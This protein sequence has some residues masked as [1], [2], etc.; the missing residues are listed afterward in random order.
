MPVVKSKEWAEGLEQN[1]FIIEFL[2]RFPY[3]SD[4]IPYGKEWVTKEPS[5]YHGIDPVNPE[6]IIL[7]DKPER[8]R[9]TGILYCRGCKREFKHERG[10][11]LARG[12]HERYCK[13]LLNTKL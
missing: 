8:K 12:A 1:E 10:N 6:L 3:S 5:K 9:D 2:K 13:V 7:E 4:C 11:V